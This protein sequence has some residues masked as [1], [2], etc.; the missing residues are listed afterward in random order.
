MNCDTTSNEVEPFKKSN[1]KTQILS[2]FRKYNMT[3]TNVY[4]LRTIITFLPINT[5]FNLQ[6]TI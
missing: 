4:G 5:R 6:M 3:V 2:Y 1:I